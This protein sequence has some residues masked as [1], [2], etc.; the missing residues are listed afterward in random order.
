MHVEFLHYITNGTGNNYFQKK[1][2]YLWSG[3]KNIVEWSGEED[4]V[5]T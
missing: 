1:E 4:L 3:N 5:V 2:Y